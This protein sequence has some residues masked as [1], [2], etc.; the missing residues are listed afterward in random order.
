[1]SVHRFHVVHL[2]YLSAGHLLDL[3]L[4]SYL[5]KDAVILKREHFHRVSH[6]LDQLVSIMAVW[7]WESWA[8]KAPVASRIFQS[9]HPSLLLPLSSSW[10]LLSGVKASLL[11]KAALSTW[12]QQQQH[13]H[14]LWTPKWGRETTDTHIIRVHG[15]SRASSVMCFCGLIDGSRRWH[16]VRPGTTGVCRGCWKEITGNHLI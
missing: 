3:I 6:K 13:S 14:C 12:K 2:T 9:D 7:N 11:W 4:S 1:M 16:A 10:R 15:L 8:V 5:E